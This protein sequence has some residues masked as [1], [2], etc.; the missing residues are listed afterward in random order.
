M[1]SA[2][3][4]FGLLLLFAGVVQFAVI[5][6]SEARP[7]SRDLKRRFQVLRGAGEPYVRGAR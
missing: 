4:L 3:Q 6:L 2:A 5:A 1:G 7:R